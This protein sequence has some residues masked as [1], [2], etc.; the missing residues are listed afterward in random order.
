[1]WKPKR[2]RG[3][4]GSPCTHCSQK[5][6]HC[7]HEWPETE[8]VNQRKGIS[9]ISSNSHKVIQHGYGQQVIGFGASA[10]KLLYLFISQGSSEIAEQEKQMGHQP[11]GTWCRR[12][13]EA[14]ETA[15]CSTRNAAHIKLSSETA[16]LWSLL[17][18]RNCSLL[19]CWDS[20]DDG[21]HWLHSAGC[22]ATGTLPAPCSW[23]LLI[24]QVA[25]ASISH[26]ELLPRDQPSAYISFL[27][28]WNQ[29]T[30]WDFLRCNTPHLVSSVLIFMSRKA[31]M[32]R[33]TTEE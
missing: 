7:I 11:Q 15:G 6:V 32:N 25:A 24:S 10:A 2:C 19:P 16:A 26:S 21:L 1:M 30:P 28:L 27:L 23:I 18:L 13:A 9:C 20:S 4:L 31:H 5:D 3:Q 12:P 17:K 22:P 33:H 14:A 8:P 29:E